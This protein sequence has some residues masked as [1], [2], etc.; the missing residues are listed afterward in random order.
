MK[1]IE[2]RPLNVLT[3]ADANSTE[4]WTFK[5]NDPQPVP[6]DIVVMHPTYPGDHKKELHVFTAL[7]AT[8]SGVHYVCGLANFS[9]QQIT[10]SVVSAYTVEDVSEWMRISND[11]FPWVPMGQLAVAGT[12]L[13][14]A[15]GHDLSHLIWR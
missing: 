11:M 8:L 2:V 3:L 1:K 12:Q 6:V 4:L 10:D 15:L 9:D 14:V 7:H 13:D 5:R